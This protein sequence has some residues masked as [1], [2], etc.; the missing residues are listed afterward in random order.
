MTIQD[1]SLTSFN[2]SV[3]SEFNIGQGTIKTT[4]LTAAYDAAAS[5][6]KITGGAAVALGNNT[7]QA[8]FGDNGTSGIVITNRSLAE[9]GFTTSSVVKDGGLSIKTSGITANYVDSTDTFTLTGDASF[10][11][12]NNTVNIG[13]GADSTTGIKIVAGSVTDVGATITSD[14]KIGGLSF[15]STNLR[16]QF[17]AAT[18]TLVIAGA[19][20]FEA[21]GTTFTAQFG[22][23]IANGGVVSDGLVIQNGSLKSLDAAVTGSFTTAKV[24]FTAKSIR[25]N[26][27]S[28]AGNTRF[29]LSGGASMEFNV[30][31]VKSVADV[32]FG[33]NGGLESS[34]PTAHFRR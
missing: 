32:L 12:Q 23:T 33:V 14:L 4:N 1:G 13:L 20:S 29:E 19:T 9:L 26:Y 5:T 31:S 7:L 28:D 15:K 22:S 30:G 11:L 25:L 6:Y 21:R 3:T 17:T 10:A 2:F 8:N 34:L 18:S 16:T 27:R 24:K